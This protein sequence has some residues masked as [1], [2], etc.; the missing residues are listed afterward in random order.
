MLILP[1]NRSTVEYGSS[2]RTAWA[3]RSRTVSFQGGV[4]IGLQPAQPIGFDQLC[5]E[6]MMEG[7]GYSQNRKLF[8]EL[9]QR[10][11]CLQISTHAPL[12]IQAILL[13]TARLLEIDPSHLPAANQ[14]HVSPLIDLWQSFTTT[15]DQM[16]KAQ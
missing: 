12:T 13:G 1:G 7:L 11:P 8:R 16:Q 2:S 4:D 3:T 6:A 9:A 10:V 5:Y 15:T 14:K